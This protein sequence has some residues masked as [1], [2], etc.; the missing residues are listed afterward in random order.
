MYTKGSS[1]SASG[2]VSV[3][4]GVQKLTSASSLR[5]RVEKEAL[6]VVVGLVV[7]GLVVVGL[8][9]GMALV[10]V[11]NTEK[12]SKEMISDSLA[13]S[14]TLDFFLTGVSSFSVSS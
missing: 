3:A 10:G 9:V 4:K 1:V 12:D 13:V 8:A 6:D 7:V 5:K 14:T 11:F 2:L